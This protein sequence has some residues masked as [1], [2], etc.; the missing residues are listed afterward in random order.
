MSLLGRAR[1]KGSVVALLRPTYAR[2]NDGSGKILS[3]SYLAQG[4]PCLIESLSDELV[5]KLYGAE[6]VVKD[7]CLL[8]NTAL[9]LQA[10]D[11]VRVTGGKRMGRY[12]RTEEG[13]RLNDLRTNGH[14]DM[15]LVE[16]KE[17]VPLPV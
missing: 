14:W 9:A 3:T 15:P 8:P 2:N 6:R 17:A 1:I 5:Q 4:E 11:V 7:R 10:G 12:Y 13:L 16:L